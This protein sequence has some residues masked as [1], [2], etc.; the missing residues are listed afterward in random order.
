PISIFSFL[1]SGFSMKSGRKG[2]W[3]M[4]FF[5][6]GTTCFSNRFCPLLNKTGVG[7]T[8]FLGAFPVWIAKAKWTS[9]I[10][11]TCGGF[12]A[13]WAICSFIINPILIFQSQN[14]LCWGSPSFLGL[15]VSP[16]TFL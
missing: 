13:D 5:L 16:G 3:W 6:F 4:R 2:V 7:R 1:N 11:F 10:F 9:W 8:T 14:R 15:P 12:W